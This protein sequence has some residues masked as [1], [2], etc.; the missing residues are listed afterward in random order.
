MGE[1]L[2]VCASVCPFAYLRNRASNGCRKSSVDR[3]GPKGEL[4]SAADVV[5]AAAAHGDFEV[6]D[7][8]ML[9]RRAPAFD[10]TGLE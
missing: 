1:V 2:R 4:R 9:R 6:S 10:I 3:R 5:D 8:T 7:A